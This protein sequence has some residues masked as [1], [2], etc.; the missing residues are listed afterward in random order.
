MKRIPT[1]IKNKT[2]KMYVWMIVCLVWER[3]EMTEIGL[4]EIAERSDTWRP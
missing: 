2:A 1:K 4:G 3:N